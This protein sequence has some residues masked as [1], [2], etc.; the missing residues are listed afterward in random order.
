MEIIK[1]IPEYIKALVPYP[2]GK[3]IEE[4]ER[5]YGVK[6]PIKLASNENALGPSPLASEAVKSSL[7]RIHRYPDGSGYYL[8]KRLA[9]IYNVSQENIVLGNGSNELIDFLC[10][11]FIRPGKNAI[12]S[13][14]SFLVY[15]KMVQITGGENIIIP[16]KQGFHDLAAILDMVNPE[17]R[18]IFLDNPNNPMGTIVS[19]SAF[20]DFLSSLPS[21]LLV[22]L[23][24]A[25]GE[26]VRP[27]TDTPLGS[28]Y[29]GIDP[30]VVT[31]R[32]FSKAYGLAG[33]RVGY[34]LMDKEI[35]GLLERVRQPF[36]V[37]LPAQEAALSALNDEKHLSKTLENTWNEMDR[38]VNELESIGCKALKSNTNFMLVETRHNANQIYEHMLYEGVII[39]SM[40]AYGFSTCIRIT[41]GNYEENQRL[42]KAL[43]KVLKQV[44]KKGNRGHGTS[45]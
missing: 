25:Y 35:S 41:I 7:L 45:T 20:E 13:N 27:G 12:S 10:R 17:T 1:D 16:L 3:P 34:G 33:L 42:L 18:L 43:S 40:N 21:H 36:N 31:L 4:L 11:L 22:V 32:T 6:N 39:R 26:F 29:I 9:E 8:K 15:Q 28:S 37:N 23:D 14:P 19:K 30:R 44:S 5:Q 2:T 24:E 38:L